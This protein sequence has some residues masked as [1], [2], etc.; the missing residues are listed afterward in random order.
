MKQWQS[1]VD[2][3]REELKEYGELSSLLAEQRQAI[4]A[5][6]ADRVTLCG[7]EIHAQ[8][9]KAD[10]A[11]WKREAVVKRFALEYAVEGEASLKTLAGLFPPVAE[12]L[13]TALA[14]EVERMTE[15]LRRS[16]RQNEMFAARAHA[17]MAQKM[18]ALAPT[19]LSRVYAVGKTHILR[20]GERDTRL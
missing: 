19:E 20:L 11:R 14:N 12:P 5:C 10:D 9:K 6:D 1:L 17:A 3:A 7:L 15:V 4:F 8:L 2:V 18:Q 16:C 13:L